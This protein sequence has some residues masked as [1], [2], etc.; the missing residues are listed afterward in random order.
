LPKSIPKSIKFYIGKVYSVSSNKNTFFVGLI[1]FEESLKV[2][3][4]RIGF[5]ENMKIVT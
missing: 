5:I 4:K 1:K 3:K 2:Q